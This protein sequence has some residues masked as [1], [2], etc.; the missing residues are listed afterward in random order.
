[1]KTE[2]EIREALR[3]YF[4]LG[5]RHLRGCA[6]TD[7]AELRGARGEFSQALVESLEAL[8]HLDHR[9]DPNAFD[10]AVHVMAR[11]LDQ[12]DVV[13]PSLATLLREIRTRRHRRASRPW[14]LHRWLE[15]LVFKRR[16]RVDEALSALRGARRRLVHLHAWRNALLVTL[17]EAGVY[18][19][20]GNRIDAVNVARE[21]W[22]DLQTAKPAPR[23]LSDE[24]VGAFRDYVAVLEAGESVVE[25]AKRIREAAQQNLAC[26]GLVQ[27][28]PASKPRR[29]RAK[30]S[31]RRR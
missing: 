20:T 31:K 30:M 17:D 29:G 19:E 7:L 3:A 4:C 16:H 25:A 23:S 28:Q 24:A 27:T 15:A 22:A 10:R 13:R 14:V 5:Q 1:M 9:V 11:F 18:L 8:R 2:A 21:T 12:S 6:Y 26:P